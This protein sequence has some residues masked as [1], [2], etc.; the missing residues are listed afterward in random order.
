VKFVNVMLIK[1]GEVKI[2]DFG[3]VKL[4]EMLFEKS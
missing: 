2:F 3:F 1:G 4:I